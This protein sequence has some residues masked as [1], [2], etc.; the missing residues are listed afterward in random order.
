MLLN[1]TVV[2][3]ITIL[4]VVLGILLPLI[5]LVR[6]IRISRREA[7]ALPWPSIGAYIGLIII[8]LLLSVALPVVSSIFRNV[9]KRAQETAIFE[10]SRI[11]YA[12]KQHMVH[13]G[14]YA[15]SFAELKWHPETKIYSFHMGDDFVAADRQDIIGDSLPEGYSSFATDTI[16]QV[17]AISNIDKDETPDIWVMRDGNRPKHEIDDLKQ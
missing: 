13:Q 4:I 11:A 17:V 9:G 5:L 1:E 14:R 7:G 2:A 3:V 16:Y 12:Q 15:H 10:L 8:S 6:E